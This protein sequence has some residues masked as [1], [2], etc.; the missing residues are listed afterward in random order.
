MEQAR[1]N[2]LN[3]LQVGRQDGD[4]QKIAGNVTEGEGS[5]LVEF[6][7]VQRCTRSR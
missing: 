1:E 5:L 4:D 6:E 3:A 2:H 7:A